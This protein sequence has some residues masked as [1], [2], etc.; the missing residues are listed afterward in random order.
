MVWNIEKDP[1]GAK[2]QCLCTVYGTAEAVPLQNLIY[3]TSS[4]QD[5]LLLS[6]WRGRAV[7][8]ALL[9][10]ARILWI[11]GE[12]ALRFSRTNRDIYL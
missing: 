4:R 3:A 5:R 9:S 8:F 6:D 2:A 7:L 10:L 12:R 11:T 1:S